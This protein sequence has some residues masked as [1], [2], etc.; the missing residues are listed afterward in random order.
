M[1]NGAPAM[2]AEKITD[3][4]ISAIQSGKY[5]FIKI[6]I[7]NPDMVGHTGDFDAVVVACKTAD[8]C[9]G[10]L[11][12]TCRVEGANLII[13]ADH[14]NAEIMKYENGSPHTSH[15]NSPVPF[16]VLPFGVKD[17]SV[18]VKDGRFGLTNIAS[19]V[20]DL[21]GVQTDPRFNESIIEVTETGR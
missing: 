3:D 9:I 10:R 18:K 15:T 17:S 5:D 19:T 13:T 12:E 21:L 4:A 7:A 6:N 20:C 1:Y 14:G 11:V 8:E 16:V 2:Q